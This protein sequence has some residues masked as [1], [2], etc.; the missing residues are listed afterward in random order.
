METRVEVL[1]LAAGL[2]T[3]MKS[4]LAKVLHRAGGLTLIEHVVNAASTITSPGSITIVTGHQ[5]A[6]VEELLKG[7]GVRFVYQKEQLGTGH[8]VMVCREKLKNIPGHVVVLYGDCPLLSP[9]A[10]REL[11]KRQQE[12]GAAATMITTELEDPAGYGRA[13]VGKDGYVHAVVE[14]KAATPGQ[15]AIKRINSGIYCFRA[16]R[17]WPYLDLI[18][19]NNAA[20]EYYLTDMVEV[21]HK[22]GQRVAELF[23]SDASELLGINTRIELADADRVF[24]M[25]KVRELMLD[26]ATIERPETVIIDADVRVGMDTIIEQG[27]RLL[28]N[29]NIGEECRIGTNSVIENSVIGD[30]VQIAPLTMIN[31]SRVAEGAHI[32][33]YSRLRMDNDVGAGAHIGNFVELKKTHLAA[34][35]KA[36]HL[37][38]LGDSTIGEKTN[39]GA[40]TIT[41]NYDGVHKHQTRIG[42][43]AFVGSNSTLVAPVSIGDGSYVAAAS[44]ITNNVPED[45]LALGRAHQVIKEG[46]AATRRGK[47]KKS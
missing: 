28:G 11:L 6:Q 3:R 24:R 10:L 21:L 14:Q 35:A 2:G 32:G 20:N 46:W 5:A 1:I 45:A 30:R 40:G 47:I 7:R 23:L 15:L 39:I 41:C 43:G 33:P 17:L 8:A 44:V 31:R 12:S 42:K 9:E 13:I 27:V 4:K 26:G 34:G 16:D 36:N 22:D 25:R 37:A 18:R 38:Y 29:T 19:P